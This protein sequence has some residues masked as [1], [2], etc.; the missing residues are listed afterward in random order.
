MWTTLLLGGRNR[1]LAAHV[2][3]HLRVGMEGYEV[4][5]ALDAIPREL[6][7]LHADNPV[8]RCAGAGVQLELPPR[9]RSRTPFWADLPAGDPIPH[10]ELVARALAAA[11]LAWPT[12]TG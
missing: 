2:A 3:D 12:A 9:V 4:T 5:D 10:V 8:N 7:G 11:A 1:S 6:R